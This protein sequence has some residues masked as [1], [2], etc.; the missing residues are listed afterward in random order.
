HLPPRSA[1][2]DADGYYATLFHELAHSTGH[3]SRLDRE[4]YQESAPF[5]S[6]VYSREELVAEFAAAFLCQQSGVD[7]SRLDQ[8]AAYIASWLRALED[9]RRLA[10]AAAGQAQR[11]VDHILGHA[12]P[13][14]ASD[15]EQE[16]IDV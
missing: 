6:P 14:T 2:R 11:A 13:A 15:Q 9:D 3:P 4:G 10:V 5:G 7:A 1:F 8:S 16:Q 12:P